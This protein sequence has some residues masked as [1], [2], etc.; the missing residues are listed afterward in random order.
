MQPHN[1]VSVKE[2]AHQ[3]IDL[4]PD[5]ASW[6]DVMYELMVRKEIE[7]GMADSMAGRVTLVED[8]R[9]EYGLD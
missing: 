7:L 9:K 1:I 2:A 5:N 6:D 4:L 3:L 8:V